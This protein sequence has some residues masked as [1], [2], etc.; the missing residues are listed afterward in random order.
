MG[1]VTSG[2]E[3]LGSE[4]HQVKMGGMEKLCGDLKVGQETM[5]GLKRKL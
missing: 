1:A 5:R 2:V 3:N 4:P